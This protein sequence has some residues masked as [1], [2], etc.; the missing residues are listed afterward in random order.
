L[1]CNSLIDLVVFGRR[2]GKRILKDLPELPG[3]PRGPGSQRPIAQKIADHMSRKGGE[4]ANGI[5]GE[6]QRLMMENCS[7]YRTEEGLR[8]ALDQIEELR[9]RYR[10]VAVENRGKRY[11]TDLLEAMELE[12]LLTL[13][14]VTL[15]SA[16]ARQ[17]SRGSH[18]REDFP[19]R[20]DADWLKHTLVQ[21]TGGEQ[22]IYYKPV[23]VT[24]FE[25]KP[26]VY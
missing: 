7:V 19:E 2:A 4:R 15:L 26:R 13:A 18:S 24:R 3:S 20:N 5:R 22:R 17:E 23:R 11:N 10:N 16:M 8:K 12:S 21:Q 1:G 14:Q 25:P 6:M 9:E